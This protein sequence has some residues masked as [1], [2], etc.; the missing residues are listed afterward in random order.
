MNDTYNHVRPD[1]WDEAL[2]H[3]EADVVLSA[4]VGRFPQ[5]FLKGRGA[6]F[7]TLVRAVVGQ[8]ISVKAADA[9][10]SRVLGCWD[11][12][13]LG[14][15]REVLGLGDDVLR[16]CGLSGQKVKYVRGIAEG[17]ARGVVHPGL[18]EG[19]EDEAVIAELVKLPGIGRWTA[20]MFLI[21]NL[22]R[23]DVLPLDDLGLLK[24]F[25]K[26]YGPVRGTARL[27]GTKRWKKIAAALAKKAEAWRPYRTVAVWYLWRSLDPLEVGY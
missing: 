4:V 22:L 14:S 6:P 18:W 15:P 16:G 26:L 9:V 20:E 2:R 1:Y 19:M 24:G 17:F 10:W 3:L 11:T 8:Q 13:M 21:F 7:E 23:P 27:E 25:E 12:G 5:S